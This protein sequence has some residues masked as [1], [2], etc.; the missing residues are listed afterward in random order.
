MFLQEFKNLQKETTQN[1]STLVTRTWFLPL[2]G[3]GHAVRSDSRSSRQPAP[4]VTCGLFWELSSGADRVQCFPGS[5]HQAQPW[6]FCDSRMILSEVLLW[7]LP[8]KTVENNSSRWRYRERA[9]SFHPAGR[10]VDW[11]NIFRRSSRCA[12]TRCVAVTVGM[13]VASFVT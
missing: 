7:K 12:C 13:R 1:C 8:D 9:R 5:S 3:L 2:Q 11:Q 10:S 4:P 6:N